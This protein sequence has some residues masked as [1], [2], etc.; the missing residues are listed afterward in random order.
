MKKILATRMYDF[1]YFHSLFF[2]HYIKQQSDI[3]LVF[4]KI[5]HIDIIKKSIKNYPVLLIILPEHKIPYTYYDEKSICNFI[6][7]Q[8]LTFYEENYLQEDAT[9]LFADDD[10]FYTDINTK[11]IISRVVFSEWYLDSTYTENFGASDFYSL[12]KSGNCRGKLLNIWNDPYYKE[13][14]IKVSLSNL[15]FFRE[16]IYSNAFHRV[17]HKN[18]LIEI[19]K[20]VFYAQHLKGIPLT[21]AKERIQKSIKEIKN[22][23]DWCSNHYIIEFKNYFNDYDKFYQMLLNKNELDITIIEKLQLFVFEESF[24]EKNILPLDWL[25]I[26]SNVPSTFFKKKLI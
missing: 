4:C 7:Q 19:R 11:S 20:D 16:C 22:D 17:T 10:E 9:I 15:P 1:N 14:I 18:N 13:P 26:S 6:Y 23:D 5:E 12:I 2:E 21:L 8:T 25:D 24:Y 3:V